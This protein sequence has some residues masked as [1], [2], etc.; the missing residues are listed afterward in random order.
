MSLAAQDNK[1]ISCTWLCGP[2]QA[3]AK[4]TRI[5]IAS[6]RTRQSVTMQA[7]IRDSRSFT[8]ACRKSWSW[9][10]ITIPNMTRS[11]KGLR[12]EFATMQSLPE[13]PGSNLVQVHVRRQHTWEASSRELS[14]G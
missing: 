3:V 4:S 1:M 9:I 6:G 7:Q 8:L 13:I 12:R 5:G 10:I 14:G 11:E 2:R